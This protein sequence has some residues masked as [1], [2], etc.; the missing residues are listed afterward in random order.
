MRRHDLLAELHRLLGPRSYLEIGVNVGGSMKISRT[1]SIGVDPF[2]SLTREIRCDLHL[3][4][5]S[6]DEFFAREHPL[7]HFD[8]PV[9]D[10]AFIDGM[11]LSEFALRDFTNVEKHLAPTGVAVFDDVL[12]RNGLEAARVRRTGAWAGD[13]YK[14]VE[15]VARRRPDLVVVL[16]NTWPTGTAVVVGADPGS[17]VLADAYDEELAYLERKDPQT[18]P[19]EYLSRAVAVDPQVL[20]ASEAWS[21]LVQARGSGDATTLERAKD[22][23]RGLPRLG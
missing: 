3:V 5:T 1:R 6:S 11:H 19:A 21:L 17:S 10:L 8:E 18:P 7:A 20:L 12:P 13:V 14:A 22:V 23:L 15:V 9:V 2:Y 16:I 4:R